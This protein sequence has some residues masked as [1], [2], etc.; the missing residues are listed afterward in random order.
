MNLGDRP[1]VDGP[2]PLADR[3]AQTLL[4]SRC[5]YLA[6]GSEVQ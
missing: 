2:S 3:K 6:A 5:T 1:G 4:H